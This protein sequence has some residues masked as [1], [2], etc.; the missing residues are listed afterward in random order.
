MKS[1][2]EHEVLS[3]AKER[4]SMWMGKPRQQAGMELIMDPEVP[5]WGED[6]QEQR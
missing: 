1:M 6:I 5:S 2:S 4:G 3:Y